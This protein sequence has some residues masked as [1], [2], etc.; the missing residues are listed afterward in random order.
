MAPPPLI[1]EMKRYGGTAGARDQA[2]IPDHVSRFDPKVPHFSRKF[3]RVVSARARV[4]VCLCVC[5]CARARVCV[6]VVV[7]DPVLGMDVYSAL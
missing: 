1:N 3:P 4:Y 6:C 2:V 5:V 7:G